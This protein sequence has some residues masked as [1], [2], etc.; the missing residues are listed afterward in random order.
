MGDKFSMAYPKAYEQIMAVAREKGVG[1]VVIIN[2]DI[3]PVDPKFAAFC[4]DPGCSGFGQSMSCPPNAK[5]P[6]WFEA[7]MKTFFHA[8]VFKYDVPTA[9][10]LGNERL[11][12]LGLIQETAALLEICAREKG[13]SRALGFAGG[14]C[15]EVFCGDRH[16]C[17]VLH[18][19]GPC[20][21]PDRARQSMSAVGINFLKL[22]KAVGWEMK[23]I[24][25]GTDPEK[26]P[27]G[28]VAGLVLLD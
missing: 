20:R 28:I 24:T 27:M 1:D 18:D 26:N 3:I 13:F 7:T 21:N 12:L 19:G 14:S 4:K 25:Q 23:I 6:K 9:S 17:K 16:F 8:L 2:T 5:G 10:L 11:P 22:C 15:K